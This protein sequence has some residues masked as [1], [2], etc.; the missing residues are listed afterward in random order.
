[1]ILTQGSKQIEICL[2]M[3]IDIVHE[4][5]MSVAPWLIACGRIVMSIRE[6]TE[7][8]LCIGKAGLRFADNLTRI[9]KERH[10][11]DHSPFFQ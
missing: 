7:E 11:E 2:K 9:Q 1:M 8:Y 6:V 4:A 3:A 10:R 5:R